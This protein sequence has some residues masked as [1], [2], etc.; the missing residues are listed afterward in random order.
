MLNKADKTVTSKVTIRS[1]STVSTTV[2]IQSDSRCATKGVAFKKN[3]RTLLQR[4]VVDF[5]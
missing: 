2:F 3:P 4:P 1:V 5:S